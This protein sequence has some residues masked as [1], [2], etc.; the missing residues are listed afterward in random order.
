M[1]NDTIQTWLDSLSSYTVM[2]HEKTF[3]DIETHWS[4]N[5]IEILASRNVI[6]GV[7]DMEFQPERPVTRAE[8]AKMLV[9]VLMSDLRR[10]AEFVTPKTPTFKD[11]AVDKWY[12]QYVETAAYYGIVKGSGGMFRPDDL[13][14]REEMALMV[15]R[16]LNTEEEINSASAGNLNCSDANNVSVWAKGA[17]ALAEQKG[18]LKGDG[19]GAF[20]PRKCA[21]RGEAAA[22]IM[23][24]ME[25]LGLVTQFEKVMGKLRISEIEGRH[26]E[27]TTCIKCNLP[28]VYVLLPV[29][30]IVAVKLEAAIGKKVEVEGILSNEMDIYMRGP[31]LKVVS[32][33]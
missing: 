20:N 8:M 28:P 18:I 23:R 21:L 6:N 33:D 24:A 10:K 31:V 9:M 16:M 25:Q 32:V 11:A 4:K 17:V 15:I 7:N 26:F 22:V 1:E 14:S 30:D 3:E 5:Y 27:L 19:T 29:D 13:I 12:Y 2:A